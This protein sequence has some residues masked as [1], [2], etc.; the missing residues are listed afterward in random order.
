MP[1]HIN[2]VRHRGSCFFAPHRAILNAH[3]AD[4]L[5]ATACPDLPDSGLAQ[6]RSAFGVG[7]LLELGSQHAQSYRPVL[8]LTALRSTRCLNARG[9]MSQLHCRFRFVLVLPAWTRAAIGSHIEV[10][11][12][13]HKL[14]IC[15]NRKHCHGNRGGVNATALLGG[16]Y[17]LPA[18]RPRFVDKHTSAMAFHHK[19]Y[20]AIALVKE[21]DVKD[22]EVW[23]SSRKFQ[24]AQ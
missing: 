5:A 22:R 23:L 19:G 1:L 11:F 13:N 17:T 21:S 18:V 20:K 8:M 15:G 12:L 3:G 2:G 24:T 7:C 9:F 6:L 4:F 10:S 14:V 16:R